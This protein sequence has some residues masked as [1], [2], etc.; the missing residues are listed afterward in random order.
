VGA[1]EEGFEP[2]IPR[3]RYY[4][5]VMPRLFADVQKLLQVGV[6]CLLFHRV[7]SQLFVWVGV[8]VGVNGVSFDVD[9]HA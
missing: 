7:C 4:G 6:F 2:S 1:E 3:V 8:S 5:A 9:Q